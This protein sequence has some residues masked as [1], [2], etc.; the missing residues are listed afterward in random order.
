MKWLALIAA[1]CLGAAG[2]PR[3]GL[4]D[5]D[6]GHQTPVRFARKPDARSVFEGMARFGPDLAKTLPEE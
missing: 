1:L 3:A 2:P 6:P 5:A 4:C